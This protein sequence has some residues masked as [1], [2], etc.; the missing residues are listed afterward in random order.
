MSF[1]DLTIIITSFNSFNKIKKCLASIDVSCKVINVENSNNKI[2][3]KKIEKEFSNV[4]CILTGKNIGYGNGNNIGLKKVKTKYALILNPDT[5]LAKNSLNKF[6]QIKK[7][8]PDFAIIGT[9]VSGKEKQQNIKSKKL[10]IQEVDNVKGHAMFLNLKQFDQVGFF[11][12][13]IFF[14]N[15]E[16]DLCLRL[17]KKNKKIYYSPSININH[18]GGESHDAVNNFSMELSR[19][20]HWMWSTFYFNKKHFGYLN[21]LVKIFPKLI[22]SIFKIF[23]YFILFNKKKCLI[24]MFRLFGILNGIFNRDSW[25]RPKIN[26]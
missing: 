24:Y 12:K 10:F 8:K 16:I 18:K 1:S 11:D 19:N 21:S 4:S 3:K 2:Y 26:R 9:S 14:F 20:W 13:K 7:I 25:Y 22:K 23:L 6:F 5:I 15:E 17:R